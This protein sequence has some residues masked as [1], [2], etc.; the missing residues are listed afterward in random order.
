MGWT[1]KAL[2]EALGE[3]AAPIVMIDSAAMTDGEA[4]HILTWA[5]GDGNIVARGRTTNG[6]DVSAACGHVLHYEL[7]LYPSLEVSDVVIVDAVGSEVERVPMDAAGHRLRFTLGP[8]VLR[9]PAVVRVESWPDPEGPGRIERIEEWRAGSYVGP[10]SYD[11]ALEGVAHFA[12]D[13][14]IHV[15]DP[16]TAQRDWGVD[17]VELW[18]RRVPVE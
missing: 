13:V 15:L 1:R 8:I 5:C 6:Y 18:R 10:R 17:G 12:R 14:S 11:V 4:I 9:H 3:L 7:G 16:I 2:A